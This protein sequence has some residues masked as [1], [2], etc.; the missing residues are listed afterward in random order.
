M[1]YT[2]PTN[3]LTEIDELEANIASFRRGDLDPVA[4]KAKRVPF[5]VYEQR[6]PETYMTRIRCTGGTITPSQ[7]AE[8]SRL[9]KDYG[10]PFVHLT[11]RQ[12]IQIHDVPLELVPSLMRD[13]AAIGLSSRGGGG[14]T[15]RNILASEDAGQNPSELFDVGPWVDALTERVIREGDSWNLPRKFKIS[16]AANDDDSSYASFN[17]LG[18]FPRRGPS[19]EPGFK[20]YAAGGLGGKPRTAILLR[21]FLPAPEVHLVVSGI[22]KFFDRN[23]NRKNKRAARLRFLRDKFGDEGLVEKLLEAVEQERST[24]WAP[25]EPI[26][27]PVSTPSSSGTTAPLPGFDAWRERHVS[28]AKRAGIFNVRVPVLLGD[29][30]ATKGIEL[31]KALESFG[32]DVLRL[33]IRQNLSL[34]GV[35]GDRLP[36]LHGILLGAG[37]AED[38]GLVESIVACTGADTCKLGMCLP[39]GATRELASRLPASGLD[40]PSLEGL[41][42]HVSGCPNTCA[43]HMLADLGFYGIARRQGEH[44]YPAYRVVA[45][46]IVGEGKARL[47]REITQV[48][49]WKMPQFTTEALEAFQKESAGRAFV[50]WLDAEGEARLVAIAGNL[51]EIPLWE[52]S[53]APY[54]DWSAT[55]PFSPA[56]G[57]AECSAG[58][59]DLIDVDRRAIA[60]LRADLELDPDEPSVLYQLLLATSRVLLITR[61]LEPVGDRATFNGFIEQF[62]KTELVP[63]HFSSLLLRA[64]E[65]GPA[66]VSGRTSEIL[67]LADLVEALYQGMDDSLR[68]PELAAAKS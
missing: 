46:G 67:E 5:G 50:E 31:G 65:L 22:K 52:E 13:L 15:V 54:I 43:Q 48:S 37:L 33:G 41:R 21:E 34:A 60:K 30:P 42:I 8:V 11:T 1:P 32:T 19:G 45:G 29:I 17:D 3:L 47:A 63:S 55:E 16:F 62:L 68:F 59:F 26:A 64:K 9:A 49:A 40:L 23:G 44:S 56:K 14:N 24:G 61:S 10:S 51:S 12:D 6:T 36:E 35:V 7:F 58:L 39:K 27:R 4:M 66:G 25:L 53:H 2:I 57:G 18:F 28:P 38:P 20:V